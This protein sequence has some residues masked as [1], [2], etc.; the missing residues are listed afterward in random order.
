MRERL[1]YFPLRFG[2]SPG[3]QSPLLAALSDPNS[4]LSLYDEVRNNNDKSHFFLDK[5]TGSPVELV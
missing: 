5:L 4:L 1:S 2:C 3:V